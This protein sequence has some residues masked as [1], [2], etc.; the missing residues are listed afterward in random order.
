M[1]LSRE[2][3]LRRRTIPPTRDAAWPYSVSLGFCRTRRSEFEKFGFVEGRAW[4]NDRCKMLTS[5]LHERLDCLMTDICLIVGTGNTKRKPKLCQ[6][7][8]AQL[9]PAI[10]QRHL[11]HRASFLVPLAG[12]RPK[13]FAHIAARKLDNCWRTH[14][15][16]L[17]S[18]CSELVTRGLP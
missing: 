3:H 8:L 9:L 16:L 12:G 1:E 5:P 13:L 11:S 15:L 10:H 6:C 18:G 4:V 14:H 7:Y 2:A 17:E